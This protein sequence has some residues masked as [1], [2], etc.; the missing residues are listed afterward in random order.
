[1]RARAPFWLLALTAAGC[2]GGFGGSGGGCAD[3]EEPEDVCNRRF[4]G[5]SL[6]GEWEL[7]AHGRRT[8]CNDRRLEGRLEIETTVPLD[9]EAEA[10]ATFGNA[11]GPEVDNE[12]DAFVQRIERADFELRGEKLPRKVS[13][14]G[15]VLGSCVMLTLTE[16]LADGD[17]LRYELN[18]AVDDIGEVSGSFTGTGPEQCQSQGTFTAR[19][20]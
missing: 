5:A 11:G 15:V 20:R 9:V 13:L 2:F 19:I 16:P 12:S 4:T 14:T 3:R 6:D 10:Q 7:H 17:T 18:G 8:G 1:M